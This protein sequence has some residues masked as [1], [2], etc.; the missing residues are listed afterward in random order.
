M[1][2]IYHICKK[3]GEYSD[4]GGAW[5]DKYSGYYI[6]AIDLDTSEGYEESGFLN[7]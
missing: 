3:Q 5:V 7:K 1:K 6:T 2:T 4:D